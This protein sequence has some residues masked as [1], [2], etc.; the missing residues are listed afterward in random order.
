MA[1]TQ[2]AT[3]SSETINSDGQL[4][5]R[6]QGCESKQRLMEGKQIKS[7]SYLLKL[8]L[9]FGSPDVEKNFSNSSKDA[10]MLM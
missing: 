10:G 7:V 2:R 5:S 8:L 3:D 9:M 1:S 4:V 6:E